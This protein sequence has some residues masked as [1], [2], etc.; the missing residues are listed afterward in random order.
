LAETLRE[1]RGA[2]KFGFLGFPK[3]GKTTLFNILTGAR[4]SVDKYA[5]GRSQPNI[6]VTQVP[7]PR[8]EELARLFKPKKTTCTHI[9]FLDIQGLQKGE[10]KDSLYLQE[11]RNVDAIAHVVRAFRD[12]EIPHSEGTI[13][14]KR[15]IETME[16]ELILADLEVAQR[17]L[18]RL[19]LNLKKAKNK[20]DEAELPIMRRCLEALERERPI[21]EIE[22]HEE[23]LK[24]IRG[25]AFLTAKPL[26]AIVNLDEADIRKIPSFVGDLGLAE[27][28][29]RRGIDLCAISAKVEEE[30]AELDASDARAFQE[31]LGLDESA[32]DR[33]IRAAFHLLGL[34]QFFTVVEDECRAWPIREGTRAPRAAGTIH[35]DFER[36]FIRAEVVTYEDLTSLGSFAA[37]R[38]KARLRSEGKDYVV[39]DGDVINFRFNV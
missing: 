10:A 30:I 7:E 15:D 34:I 5:T 18:E 16:T 23:E 36:G 22:L 35:T 2:M 1:E 25:F 6:G 13:D 39:R 20:D 3:V 38:E 32:K 12:P 27:T 24:R 14:P 9:D 33:L 8:L 17:R 31:D 19:E 21:R 26:L 28:R 29:A 37:A 4:I 11:M